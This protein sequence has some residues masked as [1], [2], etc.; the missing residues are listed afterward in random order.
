MPSL[1]RPF[2]AILASLALAGC[3]GL[4]ERLTSSPSPSDAPAL[5]EILADLIENDNA[6]QNFRASGT[7]TLQIPE[8][9]GI[10]KFHQGSIAF[11]RPADLHARAR[12]RVTGIVLFELTCVGKEYL[13]EFPTQP[14][15]YFYESDGIQF[16]SVPTR[17]S[18]SE[19]AREM[20]LPESWAEL[21]P[22]EIRMTAY[23]AE[24]HIATLEIGKVRNPR[25]RILVKGVPW[26]IYQNT[27]FDEAGAVRAKTTLEDYHEIDGL[28]FPAKVD[29]VF[30]GEEARMTFQMR[31]IRPN[32]EIKES[33][34]DIQS[35]LRRLEKRL[36]HSIA[37]P[38]GGGGS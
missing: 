20:F 35:R 9:D 33:R 17:V 19:I 18:P 1:T 23:D 31:N 4:G 34:F 5:A 2:I 24:S 13:L 37:V 30:P 7:F 36:G 32:A 6:I 14:D 11:R 27:L 22:K 29:A 16:T 15:E 12:H 25:R 28:R 10:R 38:N 3:A 26:R 21:R 8:L